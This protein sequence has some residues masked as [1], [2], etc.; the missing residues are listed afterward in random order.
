MISTS[1]EKESGSPPLQLSNDERKVNVCRPE[2]YEEM[3]E[4]V[5]SLLDCP[6]RNAVFHCK[7]ELRRF[8]AHFLKHLVN[9]FLV[10]QEPAG[11]GIGRGVFCPAADH[12]P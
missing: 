7:D 12:L 11:I 1:R 6:F 3:K 9:A 2:R 10:S 5:R 4:Q 8:L